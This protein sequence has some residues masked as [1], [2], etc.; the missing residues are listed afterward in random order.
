MT[1]ASLA[2]RS[3]A[4]QHM[5]FEDVKCCDSPR[6]SQIPWSGSVQRAIARSTCSASPFQVLPD[7]NS[8]LR[9]WRNTESSSAPH[10]S[11]WAWPCAALPMR[12]G[13]AS[14]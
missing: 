14:S 6:I 3:H 7:R 13:L 12:T 2:P 10:T 8:P 11:C 5:I 1:S 4:T 9:R